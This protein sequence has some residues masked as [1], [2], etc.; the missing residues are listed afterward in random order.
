[1]VVGL[2]QKIYDYENQHRKGLHIVSRTTCHLVGFGRHITPRIG[3][4]TH[5]RRYEL[6]LSKGLRL[7]D[8]D[9]HVATLAAHNPVYAPLWTLIGQ[10]R[11]TTATRY[12]SADILYQ[13]RSL[14][15]S[16]EYSNADYRKLHAGH[17]C[18]N[19]RTTIDRLGR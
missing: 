11:Q 2:Q 18:G 10:E 13:W 3:H 12:G 8:T 14:L 19:N 6:N 9:A 16:Q 5:S 4:I 1:M 7:G 15:Y 17:W